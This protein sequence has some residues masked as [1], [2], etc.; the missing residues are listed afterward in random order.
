LAC[1]PTS[2]HA[3]VPIR[4]VTAPLEQ[5]LYL[6]LSPSSLSKTASRPLKS[7]TLH[8]QWKSA[9]CRLAGPSLLLRIASPTKKSLVPPWRPRGLNF[10]SPADP[11]DAPTALVLL[12]SS[13]PKQHPQFLL[14]S[15][16][17]QARLP[18]HLSND[19]AVVRTWMRATSDPN[20]R[21]EMPCICRLRRTPRQ[22]CPRSQ[23]AHPSFCRRRT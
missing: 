9:P 18:S 10:L 16:P 15:S 19:P 5:A 3:H 4:K 13:T 14:S 1:Y 6:P 21:A 11:S 23:L 17:Y 8:S 2:A 20:A 7:P 12:P 22:C